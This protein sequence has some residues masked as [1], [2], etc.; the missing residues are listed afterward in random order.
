MLIL[1]HPILQEKG[2]FPKYNKE[3][4]LKGFHI[5]K[6]PEEIRNK[7]AKQGIRNAVF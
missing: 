6:L 5:K 7:I 1:L 4:Y 3:K 2:S